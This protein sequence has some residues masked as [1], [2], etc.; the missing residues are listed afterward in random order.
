MIKYKVYTDGGCEHNPGGDGAFAFLIVDSTNKIIF[1][2]S[3]KCYNNTSNNRMELMAVLFAIRKMKELKIPYNEYCIYSDSRYVISGVQQIPNYIRK[4]WKDIKNYDLFIL[5]SNEIEKNTVN[6]TWVKGHSGNEFNEVVD[7]LCT[8]ASKNKL[9]PIADIYGS[10]STLV[11]NP[12]R[13]FL[14]KE[15]KK[16]LNDIKQIVNIDK[17]LN[18]DDMEIAL[19]H[20]NDYITKKINE[21]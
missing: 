16:I 3:S 9:N 6:F 15:S 18:V 4:K 11:K 17:M 19:N 12:N 13:I 8:A 2:Y 10:E 7:K 5:I 14:S 21:K 1:D 20:V